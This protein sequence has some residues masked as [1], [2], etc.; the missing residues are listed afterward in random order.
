MSDFDDADDFKFACVVTLTH[1]QDTMQNWF[2]TN[3]GERQGPVPLV[4]LEAMAV[5]GKLDPQKDMVWTDGMPDWKLGAEVEGLFKELSAS[6]EEGFNPYAAPLTPANDLLASA[7]GQIREIEPGSANLDAMVIAKRAFEL[8][9]RNFGSLLSIGIVYLVL[10]LGIEFGIFAIERAA[11]WTT[12]GIF[13]GGVG[14]EIPG[15]AEQHSIAGFVVSTA[16]SMFLGL[17][18]ARSALSIASGDQASVATLFSQGPKLINTALASIL[19]G[20]MAIAGLLLFIVPGIILM[21]RY[22]MFQ[23]AIID[24]NL[25]VLES[26]KYSAKLTQNNRLNIFG[27]GVLSFLIM[28]AGA[29]ALLVGMI[30]AIP[31]VML[32]TPLAY[33]FLQYGPPALTDQPGT[34]TPSLRGV[35]PND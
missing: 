29:L 1:S 12:M 13:L 8:T 18:L 6:S 27:L 31:M 30:F 2:Y 21:L 24:R 11:G 19:Y 7:S 22:S 5:R 23:E 28:I 32:M 4:E 33:R 35:C 15:A 20:L 16:F 34:E 25:G 10:V 26:L 14:A 9:K 17:G 3:K